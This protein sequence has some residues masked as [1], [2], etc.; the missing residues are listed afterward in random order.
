MTTS[1]VLLL[2]SLVFTVVFKLFDI[3]SDGNKKK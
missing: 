3:W 2:L 1:E